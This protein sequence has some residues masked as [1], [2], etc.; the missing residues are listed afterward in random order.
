M[1]A[2]VTSGARTGAARTAPS[3]RA[4][5][6]RRHQNPA[7]PRCHGRCRARRP[8][9]PPRCRP[10]DRSGG[11]TAP[12]GPDPVPVLLVQAG[13]LAWAPAAARTEVAPTGWMEQQAEVLTAGQ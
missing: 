10:T 4:V 11:W 5:R 3:L 12:G 7:G 2:S 13:A 9:G 1:A 8:G 6:P